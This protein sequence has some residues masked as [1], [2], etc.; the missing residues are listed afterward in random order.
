MLAVFLVGLAASLAPTPVF[1][2]VLPLRA[3]ARHR[4]HQ[5]RNEQAQQNS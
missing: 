1:G 2:E 4:H 3:L 5:K